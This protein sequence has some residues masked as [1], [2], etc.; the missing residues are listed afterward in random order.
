M[1]LY[2]TVMDIFNGAPAEILL[3]LVAIFA[4][5]VVFGGRAVNTKPQG[6]KL[7]REGVR[8]PATSSKPS[9]SAP[10]AL[11]RPIQALVNEN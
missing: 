2:E 4:H 11:V 1:A 6:K 3:F 7:L 10:G 9:M 5:F 8:G